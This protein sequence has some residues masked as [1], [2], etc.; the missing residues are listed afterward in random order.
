MVAN[1]DAIVLA[2]YFDK[3]V[4][5]DLL[6]VKL[7]VIIESQPFMFCNLSVYI[8]VLEKV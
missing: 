3:F 2:N 8:P 6:T 5:I 1:L 4:M 7:S